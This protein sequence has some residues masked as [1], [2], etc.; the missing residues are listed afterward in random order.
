M[1]ASGESATRS[2]VVFNNVIFNVTS[3]FEALSKCLPE[4]HSCQLPDSPALATAA[5]FVELQHFW[6]FA[7]FGTRL[8]GNSFVQYNFLI[9]ASCS[10]SHR[11][12]NTSFAQGMLF[13]IR[14]SS[15]DQ[16]PAPKA[17]KNP[18]VHIADTFNVAQGAMAGQ[19]SRNANMPDQL[20]MI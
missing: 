13:R 11:I 18:K 12:L 19:A 17:K 9:L 3:H 16:P 7:A 10:K 2:R 8:N 15:F 14:S 1:Q 4:A 20:P 5:T 6:L